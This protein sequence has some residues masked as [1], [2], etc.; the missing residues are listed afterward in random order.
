MHDWP[1]HQAAEILRNVA[2]AFGPGSRILIDEVVLPDTGA[3][4]QA[5]TAD[6]AMMAFAGKERTK[7]Q[8]GVLA[9]SAGLRVEQIHEYIAFS[10]TSIIVLALK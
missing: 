6:L 9:E 8:W 5:T 10:Y 3:S 7:S 1:D 2:A 4:W